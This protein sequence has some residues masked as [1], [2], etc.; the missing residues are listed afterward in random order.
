[1]SRQKKE[2]AN[3]KNYKLLSLRNKKD[4]RKVERKGNSAKGARAH[5]QVEKCTPCDGIFEERTAQNLPNVNIH[6]V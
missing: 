2:S 3:L 5:H 4:L 6:E 1:M